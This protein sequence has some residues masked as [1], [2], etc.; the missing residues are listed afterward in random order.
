MN[1]Q[2]IIDFRNLYPT[3]GDECGIIIRRQFML[4]LLFYQ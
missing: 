2:K 3:F 4:T 1:Y